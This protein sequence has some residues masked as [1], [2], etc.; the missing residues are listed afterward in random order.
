M[1]EMGRCI[2][3]VDEVFFTASLYFLFLFAETKQTCG[4]VKSWTKFLEQAQ[5]T[6]D[7][8]NE[9]IL[10]DLVHLAEEAQLKVCPH[11]IY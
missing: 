2:L 11:C 3:P 6:Y 10:K 1:L 5:K 7:E 4:V 8:S 9:K